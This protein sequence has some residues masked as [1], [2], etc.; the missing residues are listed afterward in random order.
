LLQ[1][2]LDGNC[3]GGFSC[4]SLRAAMEFRDCDLAGLVS[5]LLPIV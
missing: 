1:D 4:V 3:V 5:Y 2:V